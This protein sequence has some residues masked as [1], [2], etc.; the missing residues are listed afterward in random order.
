LT[1]F[2]FYVDNQ[3]KVKVLDPDGSLSHILLLLYT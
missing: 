1:V 2:A 3:K